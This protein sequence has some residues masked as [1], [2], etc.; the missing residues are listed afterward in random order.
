MDILWD[1]AKNDTLILTRAIS[2]DEIS[3]MIIKGDYID[4]VKNPAQGKQKYFIM[5]IRN[6]TWAVPFLIDEQ[7]RIVL[8]TAFPSRK[9]HKIYGGRN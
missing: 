4:I 7:E 2:F 1:D 5:H 9:Y 3:G 6:Y 8:K